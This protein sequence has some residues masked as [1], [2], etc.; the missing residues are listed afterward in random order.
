M[1]RGRKLLA[2][3]EPQPDGQFAA[4]FTEAGWPMRPPA[5]RL[6]GSSDQARQWIE[7]E[8]LVLALPV[9]WVAR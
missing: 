2:W 8:A 7:T 9:K 5:V 3:I 6:F 4:V 1:R